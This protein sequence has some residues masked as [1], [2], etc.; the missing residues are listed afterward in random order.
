M[1]RRGLGLPEED[2]A[3]VVEPG[4]VC[5]WCGGNVLALPYGPTPISAGSE[6]RLVEPCNILGRI[7]GDPRLLAAIGAGDA[8]RVTTAPDSR[9][10]PY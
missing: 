10:G 6:C 1:G 4:T 5:F 2:A 3:D 8:I 9:A 7:D